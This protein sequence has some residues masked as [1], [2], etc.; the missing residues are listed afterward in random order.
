MSTRYSVGTAHSAE[1]LLFINI[2]L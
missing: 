2:I 1:V